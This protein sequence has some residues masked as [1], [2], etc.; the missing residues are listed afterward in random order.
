MAPAGPTADR[1]A[2]PLQK[3]RRKELNRVYARRHYYKTLVG[4]SVS[5]CCAVLCCAA[6]VLI[7]C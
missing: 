3:R 5:L 1:D 7:G 6:E 4:R 2:A